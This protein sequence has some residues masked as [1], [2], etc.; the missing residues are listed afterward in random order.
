MPGE[1]HNPSVAKHTVQKQ[2]W[3][4]AKMTN[5]EKKQ[6]QK[7]T[8]A[9]AMQWFW[10]TMISTEIWMRNVNLA[11][12]RLITS[13]LCR[14][15]NCVAR[16]VKMTKSGHFRRGLMTGHLT[17]PVS[18]FPCCFGAS[19]TPTVSNTF[20]SGLFSTNKMNEQTAHP[21]K[22]QTNKTTTTLT[23]EQKQRQNDFLCLLVWSWERI[24]LWHVG[25]PSG[26]SKIAFLEICTQRFI[27]SSLLDISSLYR[28]LTGRREGD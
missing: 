26:L 21:H 7:V 18:Y 19:N 24:G 2:L 20:P 12:Y 10:N 22:T 27:T 17:C 13:C 9:K 8:S 28:G 4:K 6:I 14:E 23:S 1:Q 25:I 11:Y 5:T 16:F 15:Q 3:T